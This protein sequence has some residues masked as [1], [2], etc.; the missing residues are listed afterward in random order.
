MLPLYVQNY[1]FVHLYSSLP[2]MIQRKSKYFKSLTSSFPINSIQ[3]IP[4]IIY[5]V[6]NGGS[7]RSMYDLTCLKHLSVGSH[8]TQHASP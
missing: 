8:P 4:A 2:P 6:T 7:Q 1:V 5:I 3:K